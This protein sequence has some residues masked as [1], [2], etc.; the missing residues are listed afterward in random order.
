MEM[1]NSIYVPIPGIGWITEINKGST[2]TENCTLKVA[3]VVLGNVTLI[4]AFGRL[5]YN[6]G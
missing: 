3:W 6:A 1:E 5:S 2:Q 4:L